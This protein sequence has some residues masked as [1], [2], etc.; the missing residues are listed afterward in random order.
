MRGIVSL[1]HIACH[2]INVLVNQKGSNT[3]QE[4]LKN[5]NLL[6]QERCV[7]LRIRK[8]AVNLTTACARGLEHSSCRC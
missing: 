4:L 6:I 5:R 7:Y 1:K 2:N 8:K 3:L